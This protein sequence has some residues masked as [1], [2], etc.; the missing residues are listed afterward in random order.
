[1]SRRYED[2]YTSKRK[3]FAWGM[4]SGILFM[5]SALSMIAVL[6]TVWRMI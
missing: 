5:L 6:L 3:A 4:L 2:S 1:M